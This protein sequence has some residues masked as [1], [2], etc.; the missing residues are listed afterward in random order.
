MKTIMTLG[1]LIATTAL[2]QSTRAVDGAVSGGGGKG[3]VCRNANGSLR[4]V[5]LLDLW[6]GRLLYKETPVQQDGALET[7]V[8]IAL[9]RMALSFPF[10]ARDA[11]G[12]A[13]NQVA[14]YEMKLLAAQRLLHLSLP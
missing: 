1:I 5:D 9:D 8:G 12:H 4:S 6:E 13:D 11:L 2:P 7:D 14:A 3:V 10:P